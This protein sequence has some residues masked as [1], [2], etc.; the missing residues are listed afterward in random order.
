VIESEPKREFP[1][2]LA[3]MV[4]LSHAAL[5]ALVRRYTPA[6]AKTIWPTEMLNSRRLPA[7][8]LTTTPETMKIGNEEFLVPQILGNEELPIALS[9]KKLE[10]WGATGIDINMGCPVKKALKHNYGVALMGDSDYAS[11]VVQMTVRNTHLPVG[12]KLRAQENSGALIDFMKKLEAAGASW[13]TLHPR[14]ETQMRRGRADWSKI[15]EARKALSIPVIGNGDIQVQQDV[16]DMLEQTGVERV[17]AGRALTARPWLMWQVGNRLGFANPEGLVGHPP[18]SPTE[19]GEEY[20]RALHFFIDAVESIL[21]NELGLRKIRF[22]VKT[23]SV[24]LEYGHTLYSLISKCQ[25]FDE[26]REVNAKF[27][28]QTQKM[29][30]KTELRQ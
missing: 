17:M 20:G 12:V 16:F 29:I 5:R 18:F 30:S 21:P 26:L 11:E 22:F 7:E 28:S 14:L 4:G 24:W 1:V 2:C 9:L 19:E 6:N 3:P 25:S 27:F 15:T 8:D 13:L 23:G 10:E